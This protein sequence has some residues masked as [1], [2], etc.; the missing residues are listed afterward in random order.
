MVESIENMKRFLSTKGDG[1]DDERSKLSSVIP[2]VVLT[3]SNKKLGFYNVATAIMAMLAG[4][5]TRFEECLMFNVY[6]KQ[7]IVNDQL[8]GETVLPLVVDAEYRALIDIYD[9]SGGASGG[10]SDKDSAKIIRKMDR[11]FLR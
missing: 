10:N 11:L 9:K 3:G 7:R 5:E 4:V 2:F 8:C 6:T 1:P